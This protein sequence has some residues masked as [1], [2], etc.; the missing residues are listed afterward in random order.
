VESNVQPDTP[1]IRSLYPYIPSNSRILD[2]GCGWG[3]TLSMLR[4]ELS[5]KTVVGITNNRDQADYC[6][7]HSLLREVY[8]ADIRNV[9]IPGNFDCILMLD[10]CPLLTPIYR[11]SLLSRIYQQTTRLIMQSST[12]FTDDVRKDVVQIGFKIV[13]D[14]SGL[15][16]C[17]RV[18]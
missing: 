6:Y 14:D 15:L 18:L 10:S 12:Q 1:I 16:I 5:P 13:Q 2:I 8:H 9:H 3:A 4:C 17:D 11:L 7:E